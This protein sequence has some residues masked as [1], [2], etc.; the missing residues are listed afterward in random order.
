MTENA[1][2]SA[3]WQRWL[4]A[5][6]CAL[7]L[8]AAG[9]WLMLRHAPDD[10]DDEPSGAQAIDIGIEFAAP[11]PEDVAA[12]VG[13]G[14]TS[15]VAAPEVVEQK[16][17]PKPKDEPQETPTAEEGERTVSPK[18]P[19]EAKEE[20]PKPEMQADPST[21]SVASEETAPPPVPAPKQ[22]D[23]ATAPAQGLDGRSRRAIEEWQRAL[24]LHL[25]RHKRYPSSAT[26]RE[27]RITIHMRLD[28]RGHVV[29]ASILHSSGS[30]EFDS[31]VPAPPSVVAARG[32]EFTLPVI[33][34]SR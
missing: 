11:P 21:A 27:A 10:F 20:P 1:S 6:A 15:S 3:G 9:A 8:H 2:A 23:V 22:A 12:P 4:F 7:A 24:V 29:S 5:A 26:R 14:S 16:T 13:P 30:P 34:R 31:A 25:D 28:A 32:L 33:F 17:E 19:E 18:P